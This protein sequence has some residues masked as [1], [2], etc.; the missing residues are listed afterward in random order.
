V[1]YLLGSAVISYA[2]STFYRDHS[3]KAKGNVSSMVAIGTIAPISNIA[4]PHLFLHSLQLYFVHFDK[5]AFYNVV[6]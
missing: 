2:Q 6:F 4:Y 5:S 1:L 3:E